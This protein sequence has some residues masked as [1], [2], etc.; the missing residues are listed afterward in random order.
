MV[1]S[2]ST[3]TEFSVWFQDTSLVWNGD[4]PQ[5]PLPYGDLSKW[6]SV[7]LHSNNRLSTVHYLSGESTQVLAFKKSV[8]KLLDVGTVEHTMEGSN[9]ILTEE[10]SEEGL[11]GSKVSHLNYLL[12]I[13]TII[14]TYTVHDVLLL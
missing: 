9:I 13:Y 7:S 8:V 11:S 3:H 1:E 2:D 10:I 4:T 6:F 14:H 12:F 5:V